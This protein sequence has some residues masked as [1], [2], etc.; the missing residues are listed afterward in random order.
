[1]GEQQLKNSLHSNRL[2]YGAGAL[3]FSVQS[4]G[5]LRAECELFPPGMCHAHF[6]TAGFSLEFWSL[7]K[8]S[9][10]EEEGWH[11]V[12]YLVDASHYIAKMTLQWSDLILGLWKQGF[13]VLG[14]VHARKTM[15]SVPTDVTVETCIP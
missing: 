8:L 4:A 14:E 13:L 5:M 11:L 1:M 9:W 12:G 2:S 15:I 3:S 6:E 7:L 10:R